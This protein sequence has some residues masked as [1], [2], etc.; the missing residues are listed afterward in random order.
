[1][2]VIIK[3]KK[4]SPIL[5]PNARVH[6][7][8]RARAAKEARE[9]GFW[10][11]YQAPRAGFIPRRYHIVWYYCGRK[12][13][14]DNIVARCKSY[15][16]GCCDAF[17]VDDSLLELDGVTRIGVRHKD[18]SNMMEVWFSDKNEIRIYD[19]LTKGAACVGE[20]AEG[21]PDSACV[22]SYWKGGEA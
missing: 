18:T 8:K 15:I 6:W 21:V 11:T 4:P 5:S 19:R 3:S 14:V 2:V 1:M 20:L 10:H 13:D 12:P 16:D 17:R 7:A 22:V 9:A